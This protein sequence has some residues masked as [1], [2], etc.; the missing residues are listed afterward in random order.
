MPVE[1]KLVQEEVPPKRNSRIVPKARGGSSVTILVPT[2]FEM[3]M[4]VMRMRCSMEKAKAS[5]KVFE[6]FSK[7]ESAM[8]KMTVDIEFLRRK[9]F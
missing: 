1:T 5:D 4:A 9:G 6:E 3:S 8:M 2:L 7:L